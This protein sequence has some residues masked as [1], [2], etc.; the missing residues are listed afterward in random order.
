MRILLLFIASIFSY[1]S[2]AQGV[3]FQYTFIPRVTGFSIELSE[4][5]RHF[6]EKKF[7]RMSASP[8]GNLPLVN[9]DEVFSSPYHAGTIFIKLGLIAPEKLRYK[10][11]SEKN[12]TLYHTDSA[13]IAFFDFNV[14]EVHALVKNLPGNSF[15]SLQ[16][17]R[18]LNLLIPE[19][20]AADSDLIHCTGDLS[21][22]S[23][24][25]ALES[26]DREIFQALLI[27]KIGECG[28]HALRG[29]T[30]QVDSVKDFFQT[31]KDN[32]VKL[33]QDMKSNYEQMKNLITNL[34]AE[35]R[36]FY[37]AATGL[38]VDE[39]LEIGCKLIGEVVTSAA[40]VVTGAGATIGIGKLAMITLPKLQRLKTMLELSKGH[41]ISKKMAMESLS[42][43]I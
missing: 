11:I 20:M 36:S 34:S 14:H 30:E 32:P 9:A 6:E 24:L 17:E 18:F 5:T 41:K 28:V 29:I 16:S 8:L 31:L 19:A 43:A 27:R 26:I 22:S 23:E 2:W 21:S 15:V 39:K 42:C 3:N 10:V 33:W 25:S 7:H 37:E 40:F 35:L 13:S 38:T 4:F 12:L 1:A